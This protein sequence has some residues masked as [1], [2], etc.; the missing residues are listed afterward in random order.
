MPPISI[1]LSLFSCYLR[2]ATSLYSCHY[3][4]CPHNFHYLASPHSTFTQLFS[5]FCFFLIARHQL[6]TTLQQV[7]SLLWNFFQLFPPHTLMSLY[8]LF[9]SPHPHSS[10]LFL[11]SLF[12][13][14]ACVSISTQV[15]PFMLQHLP[16]KYTLISISWQSKVSPLDPPTSFM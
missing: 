14:L 3:S 1:L 2:P 16:C 11:S 6:F 15:F 5:L 8:T 12:L 4:S 10:L 13:F 9:L 7:S